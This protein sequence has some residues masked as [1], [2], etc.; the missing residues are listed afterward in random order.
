MTTITRSI[1]GRCG[2]WVCRGEKFF[3]SL[4][5]ALKHFGLKPEGVVLQENKV[6]LEAYK[7]EGKRLGVILR[8]D[9][10]G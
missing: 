6:A 2:M 10:P 8:D 9:A 5:E 7:S 1:H 4:D 3:G